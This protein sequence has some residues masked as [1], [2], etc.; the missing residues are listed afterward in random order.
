MGSHSVTCHPTQ[1]NTPRLNPSHTGWYSIYLPRRDERLSWPRWLVTYRDGLPARRRSPINYTLIEANAPT[2]TLRRHP[3]S[4]LGEMGLNRL[5]CALLVAM[6]SVLQCV[7]LLIRC[8]CWWWRCCLYKLAFSYLLT[9]N[10][11]LIYM[12]VLAYIH[13]GSKKR[14]SQ[15]WN[16]IARNCNVERW[17]VD[18]KSKPTRKLKHANYS[19]VFWQ[20]PPN[21]VK[22]DSYILSYTVS[23][24]VV[25]V[26][27]RHCS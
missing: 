18:L 27:L 7:I 8:H 26:V 4:E 23:K 22:I 25:A 11:L 24:L 2:T 10:Y 17:K 21:V 20:F 5:F 13:C 1:V 14:D 9:L 15:L 12:Y 6:M 19:G 3:G 16:G